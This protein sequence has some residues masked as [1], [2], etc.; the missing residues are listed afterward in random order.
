MS[1]NYPNFIEAYFK[2]NNDG[3]VPDKFHHWAGLSV[4][5]SALERKC[6]IPW[7]PTLS[8]YP[9]LYI[10]FVARPGLGKSTAVMPAVRMLQDLKNKMDGKLN[11][12]PSQMTEAEL[13]N[14]MAALLTTYND[15]TFVKEQ[16]AAFYFAS[17]AS[18]SL[19]NVYGSFINMITELY[20]C[21]PRWEKATVKSGTISIVNGCF[22]LLAASTFD[23]LGKLVTNDSIMGGFASRLN[24]VIQSEVFERKSSWQGRGFTKQTQVD[25]TK[26]LEDLARIH[27]MTGPFHADGEYAMAYEEWFAPYDR[28]RQ[29]LKSEKLQSLLVRKQT[30]LLKLSMILSAAESSDRTLKLHHWK[31]A[32]LMAEELDKGLPDMLRE[33]ASQQVNTQSGVNAGIFKSLSKGPMKRSDLRRSLV[34]MGHSGQTADQTIDAFIADASDIIKCDVRGGDILLNLIGNADHYL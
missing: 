16:S 22:N 7:S 24:Y 8:F 23:Y 29:L 33:S 11:I 20:D 34:L 4:V 3:F 9:N 31:Q 17:E 32:M 28:E 15:G 26:L 19:T 5:A 27:A 30:N 10:L 1:R 18:V 12:L 6:Y 25:Y 21:N 13:V 2:Y 14:Q